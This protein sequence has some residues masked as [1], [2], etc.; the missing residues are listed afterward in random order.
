[1]VL[2]L[3]L[4]GGVGNTA[5]SG[6]YLVPMA[7]GLF[8]NTRALR[9]FAA[10]AVVTCLVVFGLEWSGRLPESVVPPAYRTAQLLFIHYIIL[11][12]TIN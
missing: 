3:T 2:L 11:I 6:I 7:T 8:I 9:R 12:I 1:M 4:L 10:V 5:F